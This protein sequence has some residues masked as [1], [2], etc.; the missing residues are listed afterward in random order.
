MVDAVQKLGL[1]EYHGYLVGGLEP[2]FYFSNHI[3]NVI[4]PT[5]FHSIIFRRGRY[6]MVYHQPA[7]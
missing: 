3:G 6:T 4:I 1:V 5:D 7:K 2:G